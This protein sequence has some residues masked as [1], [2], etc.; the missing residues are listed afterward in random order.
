MKAA[1]LPPHMHP[2]LAQ[3][4]QAERPWLLLRL[5]CK[6]RHCLP[7][8]C[9]CWAV[10]LVGKG[11]FPHLWCLCWAG[12]VVVE[13]CLLPMCLCWVFPTAVRY[14]VRLVPPSSPCSAQKQ[15]CDLRSKLQAPPCCLRGLQEGEGMHSGHRKQE[16]GREAPLSEM[17]KSLDPWGRGRVSVGQK[18][19]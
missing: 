19:V 18:G 4:R 11:F 15:D 2:C 14:E 5:H 3:P 13:C 16:M 7:S 8:R 10:L 17:E 12:P 9:L 6:G 1:A